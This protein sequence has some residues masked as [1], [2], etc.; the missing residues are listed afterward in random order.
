MRSLYLAAALFAASPALAQVVPLSAPP[1]GASSPQTIP[2]ARDVAFPGTMQLDVDVS[3]SARASGPCARPSR[4]C[5]PG[6]MTLLFPQWL[7]GKHAP[8]GELEK[9]AGPDLHR[10]RPDAQV[11]ARR[12]RSLCLPRRRAGRRQRDRGALP[13]HDPDR[14]QP[15]P[16][17]GHARHAQ[18]PVRDGVALSGRLFHP[19]DPGQRDGDLP[20]RL[21]GRDRAAPDRRHQRHDRIT[22]NTVSYETLQD[23][24]IFAGRYFRRDDLG[25]NVSLNT[26]RRQ[27][28]GTRSSP[29]TCC[30]KH[31][32]L[33]TQAVQAVRRAP[34]RPLRLPQRDHRQDGRHRAR[35]SPLVPRT[36]RSRLF[37]RLK[38][39][40]PD[41]N[42]LPHEFTH[43]WDGK[44]RRPADL[45]TPDFRTPMR[46]SLLWVYEGQT[47]F[48]G[49]CARSPLGHDRP[50]H[51]VLDKMA[52]IAA[53]LDTHARAAN[54]ARWSTPPT[55]R[56]SRPAG[57]RRGPA[58]AQR[59]LLQRGHADLARGRCDHPQGHGATAAAWTISPAPSSARARAT[60]AMRTYTLDDI[61]AGAER[62]LP[63]RL[64]QLP[65]AAGL[66]AVG[67]RRAARWLHRARATG[68]TIPRRRTRRWR[69]R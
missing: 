9:L 45:F 51:D 8:R 29:P 7:P 58:A 18:R 56:S 40:L 44:F 50:R 25:Q 24:P 63:L 52:N 17:R 68:S 69:R 3:D 27:S 31:R 37:H 30:S 36:E 64:A 34:L 22:Y 61:V 48:W 41:Q 35:A 60:G 47:Q 49:T 38:A 12:G 54:G 55:I 62:R 42:V 16:H 43:S 33:V 46:D 28:Q 65:P 67:G 20:R 26:H 53:G 14:G 66:R 15:G 2:A 11:G 10:R 5:R 1:A 59:G 57:P 19:P 23:S 6:R 21:P 4:S 39:S 32:N 13:V